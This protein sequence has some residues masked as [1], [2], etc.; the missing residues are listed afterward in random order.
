ME[1][2]ETISVE[3]AYTR[4]KEKNTVL[5]DIRDP[6]SYQAGHAPSAFHLTND[7]LHTFMQQ[8]D[9]EQPV[10]VMCYHGNSSKGAAQYLLQQGFEAV[11]SIDGG[12]EAWAR[13]YPQDVE[14][15]G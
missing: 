5:V 11:Y 4:L 3:Q 2:F 14:F 1:Q 12:F 6:Q 8:I 13:N 9:F 7:S 10:M 15:T